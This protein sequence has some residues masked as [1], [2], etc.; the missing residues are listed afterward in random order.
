VVDT[1]V[2]EVGLADRQHILVVLDQSLGIGPPGELVVLLAGDV[3]AG[4]IADRPVAPQIAS[5]L[6]LDP[7]E[8][9]HVLK[10]F[11]I[12]ESHQNLAGLAA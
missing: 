9:R 2:D 8:K 3:L 5:L 11:E 4:E 1:L 6:V 12:V 10:G 7:Y